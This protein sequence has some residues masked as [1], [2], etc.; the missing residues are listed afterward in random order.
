MLDIRAKLFYSG[1][2]SINVYYVNGQSIAVIQ[3]ASILEPKLR[4]YWVAL[5]TGV[6]LRT[7]RLRQP[8]IKRPL[9]RK[10]LCS[11]SRSRLLSGRIALQ[12]SMTAA[13]A[14]CTKRRSNFD[15]SGAWT[16]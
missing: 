1:S 11:L 3:R 15:Q 13:M 5:K 7:Q 6:K 9:L 10:I 4:C 12:V 8:A 2:D 16:W 14:F